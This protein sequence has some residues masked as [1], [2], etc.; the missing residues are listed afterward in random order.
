MRLRSLVI[1][2]L[3]LPFTPLFG[4][5]TAWYI[6][7]FAGT[8]RSVTDPG[9]ALSAFLN[10]P[11]ALVLDSQGN[12]LFADSGNRRIRKISKNGTIS[13]IAGTGTPGYSG[14][15]GPA[16]AAQFITPQGLAI[17]SAGNLYIADLSADVVRKIDTNGNISTI[18]GTGLP[19]YTGDNGPAIAATLD[20]PY[21]LALDKAGNLYIADSNNNAVRKVTTTGTISTLTTTSAPEGLAFDSSGNLYIASWG[22]SEILKYSSSG[23]T[24]ILA[25]SGNFG[26]GGDGGPATGATLSG[27]E[28]LF[29]DSTGAVWFS[30]TSN[31]RIRKI[32]PDGNISSPIGSGYSGLSNLGSDPTG[33]SVYQPDGI[34]VDATGIVYWAESGNNRVR[35]YNPSTRQ[36]A[37]LAGTTPPLTTSGAPASLLLN[38]PNAVTSDSA[39]NIYIADTSNNVI[40]KI[41]PS[42]VSS[43]IAGTGQPGFNGDVG[44]ATA[45]NLSSPSGIAVDSQGNFYLTD[46]GNHR[47]RKVDTTGRI[48][49][50]MGA[51]SGLPFPGTFDGNALL[52]YPW[53]IA[54]DGKGGFYVSDQYFG[55][56]AHVDSLGNIALIPT[57]SVNYLYL[58]GGIAVQGST[59][60]IADTYDNRVLKS[61]GTNTSVVAGTG[62]PGFSG[63]GK[64]ATQSTL[65]LPSAVAIDS[66]NNLYIADSGNDRIRVVDSTGVIRTIAG[67]GTYGFSGDKGVAT[68][69]RLAF[70]VSL[71][72]DS[73]GNIEF[74]DLLNQ[75]IRILTLQT[76]VPDLSI[77]ADSATRSAN[78]GDTLSVTLTLASVN[79]FTGSVNLA[80]SGAPSAVAFQ[81]S[82]AAVTLTA[83]QTVT[84]TASAQLPFTLALGSSTL[85]FTATSGTLTRTATVALLVTNNPEFS[86]AGVVNAASNLGSAVSPGEIVAN[87]GQDMGPASLTYGTF[88]SSGLLSQT[89]AGTTVLF[90]GRPAPLLYTSS[91]QLAAVVPYE[92]SGQATTLIQV[93]YNTQKSASIQVNVIDAA[94][95]LFNA[96]GTQ[97][98]SFNADGSVNSAANPAPA[99][100]VVVLFGTGDGLEN[101]LPSDGQ[102]IV[103]PY[104]TTSLPFSVTIGGEPAALDYYGAAPSLVAGTFQVNAHIPADLPS[105]PA[106]V[107][108]KVGSRV[109][110]GTTTVAVK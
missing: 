23:V 65:F 63:D 4:Q 43:I 2:T 75:R 83:G 49:T 11:A 55:I 48:T 26:Y 108:V 80:A 62:K 15:G 51:G 14:D 61:D 30:D 46:T 58:P 104:P 7:T 60:Y 33:V 91:G 27:P 45:I 68:N 13:T 5:T 98:A 72:L 10:T 39:G 100:T 79:G 3:S 109:S 36:I 78:H 71:N 97:A 32:T 69:A 93:A 70:P 90:D 67:T 103:A 1:F 20:G 64:P 82:P 25:G 6:D 28:G 38:N 66:K 59:I 85:T 8:T 73:S 96:A 74:A 86:A 87:Y 102:Q 107:V 12:V 34:F 18:V 16:G 42:G 9:P 21:A 41:T 37:D 22:L 19:G 17:D 40:R 50:V 76:L 88:N 99:G 31:N 106:T 35:S 57:Q 110:T 84:V 92:V 105:G 81:F 95:A 89:V 77:S 56:V 44:Q 29:V 54:V 52:L 24:T 53:G 47:V 94:P 101:A